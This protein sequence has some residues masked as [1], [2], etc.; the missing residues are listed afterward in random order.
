MHSTTNLYHQN[1]FTNHLYEYNSSQYLLI[2]TELLFNME[3]KLAW[4]PNFNHNLAT[5]YELEFINLI[6]RTNNNTTISLP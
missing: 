2:R 6:T 1:S 4:V 5:I 3:F